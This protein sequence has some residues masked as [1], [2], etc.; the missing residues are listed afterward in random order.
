VNPGKSRKGFF[1]CPSARG[2]VVFMSKGPCWCLVGHSRFSVNFQFRLEFKKRQK[3]HLAI[4]LEQ[5]Q[6]LV[7]TFLLHLSKKLR[8]KEL[9]T[10][11][12]TYIKDKI[13]PSRHFEVV[14]TF[15]APILIRAHFTPVWE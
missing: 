3:I 5:L 1:H 15:W 9:P 7:K 11:V 10:N 4:F 13:G 12:A 6:G 2:G 8:I 14:E